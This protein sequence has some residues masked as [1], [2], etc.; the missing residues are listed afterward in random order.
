MLAFRQI[1]NIMEATNTNTVTAATTEAE[2]AAAKAKAEAE[3]KAKAEAQNRLA[4]R[5]AAPRF[6]NETVLTVSLAHKAEMDIFQILRLVDAVRGQLGTLA[7]L[8]LDNMSLTVKKADKDGGIK[9]T[10]RGTFESKETLGS[11][12]SRLTRESEKFA[13]ATGLE[14]PIVLSRSLDGETGARL[15]REAKGIVS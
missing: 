15:A 1:G 14:I 10:G 8:A 11:Q 9:G 12:I 2:A 7:S 5:L 4:S 3:A 13:K 6:H